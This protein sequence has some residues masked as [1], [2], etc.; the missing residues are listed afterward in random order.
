MATVEK[1]S[2]TEDEWQFA[3]D[4]AF[5]IQDYAFA[6][7]CFDYV[8]ANKSAMCAIFQYEGYLLR[9][10]LVLTD[11]FNF[12]LSN[13]FVNFY[14]NNLSR[15]GDLAYPL[16]HKMGSVSDKLHIVE[17]RRPFHAGVVHD[18]LLLG[19]QMEVPKT[20][21][22]F[23]NRLR[24]KLNV[25]PPPFAIKP[26]KPTEDQE[27]KVLFMVAENL[28]REVEA[29]ENYYVK[30]F[31]HLYEIAD[32]KYENIDELIQKYCKVVCHENLNA[33]ENLRSLWMIRRDLIT[34]KM[35]MYE[36][37]SNIKSK[38]EEAKDKGRLFNR[39]I[40]KLGVLIEEYKNKLTP[41]LVLPLVPSG[42]ALQ[43]QTFNEAMI[44]VKGLMKDFKT[45]L[46]SMQTA[47]AL[48]TSPAL[49]SAHTIEELLA[50]FGFHDGVTLLFKKFKE[51]I[52]LTGG[53]ARAYW[54]HQFYPNIP[55]IVH[56]Y[57]FH[58]FGDKED[59][60]QF[61]NSSEGRWTVQQIASHRGEYATLKLRYKN[62]MDYDISISPKPAGEIEDHHLNIKNRDF[63]WNALYLS[64]TETS[65][66]WRGCLTG[67]DDLRERFF[68]FP[69]Q[70]E[71]EL[72]YVIHP[73]RVVRQIRFDLGFEAMFGNRFRFSPAVMSALVFIEHQ[74]YYGFHLSCSSRKHQLKKGFDRI[75]SEFDQGCAY[76]FML[77][78]YPRLLWP[79]ID[80][81]V[82]SVIQIYDALKKTYGAELGASLLLRGL[83][84]LFNDLAVYHDM[85]KVYQLVNLAVEHLGIKAA[86]EAF[87]DAKIMEELMWYNFI[88]NPADN[89]KIKIELGKEKTKEL[90]KFYW[91]TQGR[92]TAYTQLLFSQPVAQKD[93][94]SA[95]A[96]Y[97]QLSANCRN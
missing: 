84:S 80:C 42:P 74:G 16:N 36:V 31:N 96:V 70:E 40:Y 66:K 48:V 27:K 7:T 24:E 11:E 57:D 87:Q 75:F 69:Q 82:L 60:L 10:F 44:A 88:S 58:F 35:K 94:L 52:F 62:E 13:E 28:L 5:I 90:K 64:V 20:K 34:F 21:K 29:I 61:C 86:Y 8:Y 17:A 51:N 91:H 23:F 33:L 18:A 22:E 43:S 46:G 68:N 56:D 95:E 81:K 1:E 93:P 25:Y 76:A 37:F 50:D 73:E 9:H 26:D 38:T 19:I 15:V 41:T 39:G 89:P 85:S 12:S 49:V 83:F 78:C 30:L 65:V 71:G 47:P 54:L 2:L 32:E 72:V 59:I 45:L 67:L 97:S 53:A 6:I 4:I 55:F 3:L 79:F 14:K 92:L 77:T 63:S